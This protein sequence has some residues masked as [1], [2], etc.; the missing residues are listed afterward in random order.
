[1]LGPDIENLILEF[2]DEM[3]IGDLLNMFDYEIGRVPTFFF[4]C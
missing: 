4:F 2:V 3:E 1:M